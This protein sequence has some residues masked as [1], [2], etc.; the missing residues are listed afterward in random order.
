MGKSSGAGP[1]ADDDGDF[2]CFGEP[3]VAGVAA[4][5]AGHDSRAVPVYS[6]VWWS[7]WTESHGNCCSC[8]RWWP[9]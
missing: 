7:L 3:A 6:S 5:V 1:L 2:C 9:E 4:V 8:S